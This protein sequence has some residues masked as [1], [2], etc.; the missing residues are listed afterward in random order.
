MPN[1]P[2]CCPAEVD[3]PIFYFV[4]VI[5]FLFST[6]FDFQRQKALAFCGVLASDMW[7][8]RDEYNYFKQISI[9]STWGSRLP[10]LGI[11]AK[12]MHMF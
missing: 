2:I 12:G 4:M 5:M 3:L 8:V 9:Q 11:S 10:E 1:H 7:K 6:H